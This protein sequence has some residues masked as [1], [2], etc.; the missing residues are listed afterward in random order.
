MKHLLENWREYITEDWRDTSWQNDDEK[1]TIGD[2]IDYLGDKTIDIDVLELS[3]QLP[4]L[5]TRG[6]ERVAA[7]SLEYPIIVV[8]SG[9]QYR[10]VLDGNHRLQ[11]A[12]DNEVETIKAKIL[13]LDNPETPEN[14]KRLFEGIHLN[15]RHVERPR[16]EPTPFKSKAQKRYKKKRRQNDIYSTISG[17]KNL[18]SGA[19]YNTTPQRAGTDRLRFENTLFENIGRASRLSIFDFDETIAFTT[20][21]INVINKETGDKFQT[22]SQEE[23]DAIKDDDKYEFDF[24]PLDQVND[25]TENPNITSILRERLSDS[26]TQVMVLT[27]RAP[28]SID[29]IH[30]T[31][32]T[33]DKPIETSDIIMIGVEG[34]NKGNY[35]ANVVLSKYENIKEI[36]FY[37]DS[38]GNIDDMI[39]IKKELE[40]IDRQIKF[41]IYLVKHGKPEL[42]SN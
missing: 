35:L 6:A 39:Q 9:G 41:D 2:V 27:A 17:H 14:F 16:E 5:P 24:S 26:D 28:V 4:P 10:Y 19:P 13:N 18:K 7:A 38:Q 32:R 29:D 21:V 8:K 30:R 42:V 37:D 22:K 12:I 11:K 3:Q 40:S 31:L 36:E 20:G 23:Y 15:E 1:A 25:A 34:K 33:F